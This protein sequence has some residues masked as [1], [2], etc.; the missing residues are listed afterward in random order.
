MSTIIALLFVLMQIMQTESYIIDAVGRAVVTCLRR[1][2]NG[3]G[4]QCRWLNQSV[5]NGSAVKRRNWSP[6]AILSFVPSTSSPAG[7]NTTG[8]KWTTLLPCLFTNINVDQVRAERAHRRE[9][10]KEK[11]PFSFTD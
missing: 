3:E 5:L 2:Q 11:G 6:T 4:M 1:Q 7:T 10:T 8:T 9:V